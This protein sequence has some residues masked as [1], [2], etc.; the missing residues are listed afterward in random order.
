MGASESR[1]RSSVKIQ[2]ESC[3]R[4]AIK[5]YTRFRAGNSKSRPLWIGGLADWSTCAC[6]AVKTHLAGGTCSAT[7]AA[8]QKEKN[9]LRGCLNPGL[10]YAQTRMHSMPIKVHAQRVN[11]IPAIVPKSRFGFQMTLLKEGRLATGIPGL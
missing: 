10:R 2:Q 3:C 4:T 1:D 5:A 11:L 6:G 9:E 8:V 7:G